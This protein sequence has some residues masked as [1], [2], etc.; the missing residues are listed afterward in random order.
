MLP[1]AY[2]Q[3]IHLSRYAR[4]LP[5][6][7]RRETWEETVDRYIG[8]WTQHLAEH[9][10]EALPWWEE[11]RATV[12]ES[13]LRLEVMPSM[14][15]LMTAGE[16]LRRDHMAGYNCS[17]LAVDSY[18]AFAEAMYILLCGTGVGFSV[19]R[20]FVEQLPEVP[21]ALYPLNEEFVVDD[22]KYGWVDA[23]R[24]LLSSVFETG[25]LPR[26]DYSL[27]RPAGAP[28]VTFGGRASGPEP[29]RKC[30]DYVANVLLEARGRKLT[31]LECHDI[32]CYIASV[33]VV[34]GVRRSAMISLSD[35]DDVEMRDAKSGTW[36]GAAPHRA[37][38][39]NSAVHTKE[40]TRAEFLEEWRALRDSGSGERGIFS[41]DAAAEVCRN[42]SRIPQDDMGTNPCSEIILRNRQVC[43]LTE[44]IVRPEDDYRTLRR[45]VRVATVMGT[46]QAMLTDFNPS[47]LPPAWQHNCEEEALLG[48]SLSGIMDHPVLSKTTGAAGQWLRDLRTT[49]RRFNVEC[50]E[51][52]GINPSAAITC[53]KPSGTVSQLT[54]CASGIHPRYA[55]RY[56][57]RVRND[58]KDPLTDFLIAQGVTW[59]QD[60]YN[61]ETVVFSF[62][63]EAPSHAVMRDD[64][65]A[66]EQLEHWLMFQQCWCDHKPSITVYVRPDE[67]GIVGE[68]V[69]QHR[70]A[71]SGVSFLPHSDH[72]YQQAPYE[73]VGYEVWKALHDQTPRHIDWTQFRENGDNTTASQ[74]LACVGGACDVR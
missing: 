26:F 68:W 15:C 31:T 56:I 1:T 62:P 8:F 63:T 42:I 30:L 6:K 59:E 32:M 51:V 5:E 23:L 60:S 28:L 41:R 54:D 22:S 73:E 17:F 9:R 45:K 18:S 74:E 35:L 61:P 57:R 66:I 67:W 69:W 58:R 33:V 71:M 12:R 13:I 3:Y 24:H 65:T 53:V 4:Y 43:N 19:E 52:L 55:G 27:I 50:A 20:R 44:V 10:P 25:A 11:C 29:L 14:R 16:A 37:L 72:T 21:R 64:R 40:M 36:W 39:N 34:G 47:M 38:A 2:Q 70:D 48:V 7:G 46:L 49:T